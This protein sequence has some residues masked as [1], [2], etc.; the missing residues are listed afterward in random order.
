MAIDRDEIIRVAYHGLA[1]RADSFLAPGVLGHDPEI[2]RIP[3]DPSSA[4]SL[5]Q[6]AGFPGGRGFPKLT[7]VYRQQV[8]EIEATVHLIRDNLKKNL[9]IEVALQAREAATFFADLDREAIPF[10]VVRWLALD[11]H[12]YLALLLR[13]GARYNTV[14]YSNPRFDVYSDRGDAAIPGEARAAL[15]KM[16]DA[17]AMEDVAVLP[18]NYV[19]YPYLIKPHVKG[20]QFNLGGIMPHYRTTISK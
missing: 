4:R 17:R 19:V 1:P 7:L 6:S 20:L 2:P 14:G 15:Y 13:T 11:P 10:H 12:D 16:A 5:L 8:P 3:R 18:L 9:G